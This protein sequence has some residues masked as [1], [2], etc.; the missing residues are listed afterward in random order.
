[1]TTAATILLVSALGMI[2]V[3]LAAVMAW[4]R[5]ARTGFRW[6]WIGA[7][8]WAVAVAVKVVLA[9]LTNAAVLGFLKS[10]LSYPLLLA[11]G[12]LFIG[13]QSSVCE[14][15]FTLLAVWI[16]RPLGKKAGRAIG[17]GLGAG[18]FEAFLLG[19]RDW[20]RLSS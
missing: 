9:L 3:A 6:F 19:W 17:I 10:N 11:C 8:L 5:V 12:G 2:C 18:A 16:W 7:G 13:I 15:G 1:M 4:R 14:M 20:L